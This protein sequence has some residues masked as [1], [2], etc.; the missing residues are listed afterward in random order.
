MN[1][2]FNASRTA[3]QIWDTLAI[4][5]SV[6]TWGK[7][8]YFSMPVNAS[9]E[10]QKEFVELGN[11]AYWPPGTAFAIFF[12]PTPLEQGDEIRPASPV[13]V[14]GKLIGNPK[15]FKV[16]TSGTEVKNEKIY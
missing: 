4:S 8:I 2:E 14:V 6:P 13:N 12:G 10:N 11:L 15:C 16:V 9:L 3:E 1:A 5:V 7:G